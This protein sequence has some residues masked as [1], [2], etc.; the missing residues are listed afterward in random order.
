MFIM[1]QVKIDFDI[2]EIDLSRLDEE[3]INQPKMYFEYSEELT[4]AKEVASRCMAALD[5]A[6]DNR[7]AVRAGLDLKIRKNPDKFLK[8][9]K[10][11]ETA[12]ANRV[13]IHPMYIEAQKVVYKVND[14]LI[15]ANKNV[16]TFYS[17]VNAMDHRKAALERCVS[18]HGQNYFSRPQAKDSTSSTTVSDIKKKAARKKKKNRSKKS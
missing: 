9:I 1:K 10:L 15:T 16:S 6:N 2:F 13:V 12:L 7:K 17:A 3:W 18:L 4:K 8:A 5:I 11:T 14:D